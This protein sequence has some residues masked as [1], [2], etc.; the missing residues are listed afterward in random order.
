MVGGS[1]K[2]LYYN[3]ISEMNSLRMLG[4]IMVSDSKIMVLIR[5]CLV[6]FLYIYLKKLMTMLNQRSFMKVLKLTIFFAF[7]AP[8]CLSLNLF[9]SLPASLSFS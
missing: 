3:A 5:V 9:F 1:S 7:I 8:Y 4:C 2:V 6:L